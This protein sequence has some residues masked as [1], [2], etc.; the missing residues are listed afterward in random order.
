MSNWFK[1]FELTLSIFI[2]LIILVFFVRAINDSQS[3]ISNVQQEKVISDSSLNDDLNVHLDSSSENIN[4]DKSITSEGD[5]SVSLILDEEISGNTL[6]EDNSPEN[7][8]SKIFT[9]KIH[10]QEDVVNLSI[11]DISL[12]LNGDDSN[13]NVVYGNQVI[14]FAN[15]SSGELRLFKDG[16]DITDS[17]GEIS[18]LDVGFYNY[19]AISIGNENY[20]NVSVTYFLNVTKK[21]PTE[22]MFI[23]GTN[24]VVYGSISDF[25]S[26]ES[27]SGDE[28]CNYTLSPNNG[29][30]GAGVIIFNYSTSGCL[31]FEKGSITKE[32]YVNRSIP[33]LRLLITPSNVLNYSNVT[34][35]AGFDCPNSIVCN[36][37]RN[38]VSKSNPDTTTLSAGFYV[39]NYST[40]GNSNYSAYSVY[41]NL[42]ILSNIN[43]SY[44]DSQ[45]PT[46]TLSVPLDGDVIVSDKVE[47][48]FSANDNIKVSNCTFSLYYYNN[49]ASIGSLAYS[50]IRNSM[51]NNLN[52]SIILKDFDEGDYSW[53]VICYDNS[54]NY[55][56]RG[57]DFY[58]EKNISVVIDSK[59]N[60]QTTSTVNLQSNTYVYEDE[61]SNLITQI[62]DFLVKEEKYGPDEL[63]VIDGMG[64]TENLRF[65]KKKL[66]QIKSDMDHNLDFVSDSA[67]KEAREKQI[68]A[69]LA[70]IKNNIPFDIKILDKKSYSKNTLESDIKDSMKLYLE[71]KNIFMDD[72][73][74]SSLIEILK[75]KQNSLI[76]ESEAK[77]I[78]ITYTND[79]SETFILVDKT[80][81]IKNSDDFDAIIEIIP[82]SISGS[83]NNTHFIND[84]A[85]ISDDIFEVALKS[86]KNGKLTYYIKGGN[87]A[88]VE[89]IDSVI[90]GES[91][92]L[93]GS[94]S[95]GITGFSIVLQTMNKGISFY[96]SWI[97]VLFVIIAGVYYYN[98]AKKMSKLKKNNE[99]KIAL[100]QI[101]RSKQSL[102]NNEI[103]LAR[104]HYYDLKA[105]YSKLDENMKK[106]I[107]GAIIKLQSSIDRKEI[108]SLLRE[109]LLAIKEKR[110]NDA[111]LIYAQ[112]KPIY[113]R[114]PESYKEKI[115]TK[116]IPFIR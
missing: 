18:I 54:S 32:L 8:E 80:T 110:I 45:K 6:I 5:I 55:H 85:I 88:D 87:F 25:F 42:T 1:R 104:Q 47:F 48:I 67:S 99:F 15:T 70:T 52:N 108:S 78:E 113:G 4:K 96:I 77:K 97:L 13:L 95:S 22:G 9:P 10:L 73:T 68:K 30:F 107:Y 83:S 92:L 7:V 57:R 61:I 71:K 23:N 26:Y 38:G 79:V 58:Y 90:F 60:N 19:T 20:T 36:L 114:L 82:S 21:D 46:V 101:K 106:V 51:S 14:A 66:L 76:I 93:S 28:G 105:I 53:D 98:R 37:S 94:K 111:K 116:I 69:D 41:S 115:Y 33:N 49:S 62:N 109:C 50:E 64:I 35:A 27:N 72:R 34:I 24:S 29:V 12:T 16:V 31:N 75:S 84:Y 89:K 63:A 100:E 3:D 74:L 102:D 44:V 43:S 11:G 112:I 59:K 40:T 86:L 65:Y 103:A 91:I 2:V 81:S 39:Y 17:N 56:E